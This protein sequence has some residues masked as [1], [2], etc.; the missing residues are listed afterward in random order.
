MKVT[1]EKTEGRQVF[2]N[3]E[4]EPEDIEHAR[5]HALKYF[6]KR[7]SIP[8]FRKGKAPEVILERH[9]GKAAMLDETVNHMI[10]EA[11]EKA[12]AE[13]N[14]QPYAQPNIEIVQPEPLVFKAVVPLAPEVKLGDFKQ[15]RLPYKVEEVTEEKVDKVLE[16]LRGQ[17]A[18]WE[19]VEK[20]VENTDLATINLDSTVEGKTYVKQDGIQYQVFKDAAN[21][22]PGFAD[23][24]MG[25]VKDGEKEFTLTFPE[26]HPAEG[27]TGKE[28]VFKVKL[29]EV[30]KQILP[31]L[32][33][34]FAKLVSPDLGTME[35]LREEVT[36]KLKEG[37]KERAKNEY[38]EKVVG[39]V[40]EGSEV[41]FPPVMVE[42]EIDRVLNEQMRRLQGEGRG[43][44][45][46]LEKIGKNEQELREEIRP[47]AE[48]RVTNSLILSKVVETEELS[49]S[50]KEIDAEIDESVSKIGVEAAK[51]RQF[52]EGDESARQSMDDMLLT[53]KVINLL[54][55]IAQGK[56]VTSVKEKTE[57]EAEAEVKPK[58]KP[59]AKAET[60]SREEEAEK[61]E[62]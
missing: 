15:V 16:E 37:A 62:A 49:V 58:P 47:S 43:L 41:L 50:E 56:D 55:D 33:E 18:T 8:G 19:P 30:K 39:A 27:M 52:M 61:E 31:E 21:P 22:V 57:S 48:K 13:E 51:F 11:Y 46:Y 9:V 17:N 35:K 5:K 12:I 14:I 53:R 1:R 2:L 6:A 42:M 54:C 26:D 23:K 29:I 4:M 7:V 45:D 59:K 36:T 44:E 25:M 28:G 3:L 20:P 24:L 40:A 34:E 32:N 60:A 10:P 38:Q